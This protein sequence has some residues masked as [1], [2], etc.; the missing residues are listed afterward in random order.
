MTYPE[1]DPKKPCPVCG[2]P[3]AT[4]GCTSIVFEVK[5]RYFCDPKFEADMRESMHRLLDTLL[6]RIKVEEESGG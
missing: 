3:P 1:Y 4:E 6:D 5:K 2:Y